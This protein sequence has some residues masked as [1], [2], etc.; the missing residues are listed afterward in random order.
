MSPEK[1]QKLAESKFDIKAAKAALLERVESQLIITHGGGLFKATPS[2]IAYV[3][4]L[5]QLTTG[6]TIIL[7]EYN[8]PIKIEITVFLVLLLT[9]NQ[10]ALNSYRIEYNKLKKVRKG[11]KL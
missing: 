9:A 10:Y 7:D 6:R 11:D 8:N 3:T 1:L 2:L 5:S 4:G